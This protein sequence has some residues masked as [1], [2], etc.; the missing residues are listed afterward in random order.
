MTKFCLTLLEC[1]QKKRKK[2]KLAR[3]KVDCGIESL[4]G[5]TL[6]VTNAPSICGEEHY[7][8]TEVRPK[9]LGQ[10]A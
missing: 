3:S 1:Q 2:H 6:E 9:Q 4:Y 10:M 7:V 5:P 8:V